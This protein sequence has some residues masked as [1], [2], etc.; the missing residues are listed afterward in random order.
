MIVAK[1][2]RLAYASIRLVMGGTTAARFAGATV[3]NDCRIITSRLGTEPWLI[4]IGDRVTIA[5][6]VFLLTHDGACGLIKDKRGRRHKVAP[7]EIGNDV[8]IG[9]CSVVL[10]GV[11]IGDRVIVA[12]GT[13][14]HK[15][16][17]SG[18]VVGGSPARVIG[19][20]DHYRE[21]AVER[22]PATTDMKGLS[23]RERTDSIAQRN[24]RPE[25]P[26]FWENE[27]SETNDQSSE[28]TVPKRTVHDQTQ[29]AAE[30]SSN[31]SQT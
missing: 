24:F 23:F 21:N 7:I 2:R 31:T 22:L 10:P 15:S 4:S 14:V 28:R 18:T 12:A 20:F 16:I 11:R 27:L 6:E 13:V 17:P 30:A 5:A 25:L 9:V 26:I 1:L 8:F 29:I 19:S 3:G